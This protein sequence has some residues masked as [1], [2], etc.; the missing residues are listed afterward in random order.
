MISYLGS[1]PHSVPPASSDTDYYSPQIPCLAGRY[2][3][4]NPETDA[5][6]WR[7]KTWSSYQT[8]EPRVPETRVEEKEATLCMSRP[9][10]A[11][12]EG[13]PVEP[14]TQAFDSN[15]TTVASEEIVSTHPSS[16]SQMSVD[17]SAVKAA[18]ALF[19]YRVA[20]DRFYKSGK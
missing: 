10:P 17:V 6:T 8:A 4:Y 2:Y 11:F 7:L 3:F 9:Q 13:R 20:R 1:F 18:E 14:L 12:N 19:Q 5:S 16:S 15:Q